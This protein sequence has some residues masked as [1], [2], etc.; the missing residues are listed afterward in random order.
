MEIARLAVVML[1]QAEKEVMAAVMVE[2]VAVVVTM[3]VK[4]ME[5][6]VG[7]MVVE[8]PKTA[9]EAVRFETE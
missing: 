2:V 4:V 9:E 3:E 1:G 5:V 7:E 6:E 8:V